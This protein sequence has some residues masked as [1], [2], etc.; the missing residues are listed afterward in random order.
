MMG[1]NKSV[2]RKSL[3]N[4]SYLL[5]GN[6]CKEKTLEAH[7]VAHSSCLQTQAGLATAVP[8][9]KKKNNNQQIQKQTEKYKKDEDLIVVLMLLFY[10]YTKGFMGVTMTSPQRLTVQ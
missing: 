4:Y 3:K 1:G 2:W 10:F 8:V 7:T 9:K 5:R 6:Y